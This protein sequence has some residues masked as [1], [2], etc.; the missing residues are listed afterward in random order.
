MLYSN[1][2]GLV[3]GR[4]YCEYF[5]VSSLSP[6]LDNIKEFTKVEN[7]KTQPQFRV[8]VKMQNIVTLPLQAHTLEIDSLDPSDAV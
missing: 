7:T 1:T 3:F 2:T 4:I 8:P 5:L 6:I